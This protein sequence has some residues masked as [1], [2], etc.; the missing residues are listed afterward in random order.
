M[1]IAS[2]NA[3][4]DGVCANDTFNLKYYSRSHGR[5]ELNGMSESE[6]VSN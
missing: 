6:L 2:F 1:T 3:S 5:E 4:G